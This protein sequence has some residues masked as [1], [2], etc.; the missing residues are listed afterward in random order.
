[1]RAEENAKTI[2][3]PA[4][5]KYVSEAVIE[6]VTGRAKRTLQKDRFFGRGFPFY[7]V[8][9]KVLYDLDEVLSIIQ[10]SRVDPKRVVA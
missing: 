2:K 7:R 4:E 3:K 9:G 1:M 10:A 6:T 8:Q 5:R